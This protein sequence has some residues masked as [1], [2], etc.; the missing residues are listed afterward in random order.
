MYVFKIGDRL[1]TVCALFQSPQP[2]GAG[3]KKIPRVTSCEPVSETPKVKCNDKYSHFGTLY[4]NRFNS[5][6]RMQLSIE[7]VEVLKRSLKSFMFSAQCQLANPR[8]GQG[9]EKHNS[10]ES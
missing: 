7:L 5:K 10:W 1:V 8:S 2:S 3:H 4:L 6:S 9:P